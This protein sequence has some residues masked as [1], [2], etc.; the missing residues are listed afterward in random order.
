M[1]VSTDNTAIDVMNLPIELALGIGLLLESLQHLLPQTTF[2]P[3]IKSARY[4]LPCSVASGQ[5]PPRSTRSQ[6]PQYTI[7][8]PAVVLARAT[9]VGFL[10]RQQRL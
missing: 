9:H 10:R 4:R 3:S 1:L 7:D 6:D 8:Y 5:I 2:A